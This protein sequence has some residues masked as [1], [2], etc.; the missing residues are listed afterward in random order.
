MSVYI[1]PSAEVSA[2]AHVGEGS[3]VWHQAQVCAGAQIGKN[4]IIG[5]G[6]YIDAGVKIGDNVKIQNYVSVYHGVTVED[7]V[8]IGPYVC[9]TN[10]LFPRAVNPDDSIKADDDWVLVETRICRGASLGAN[11][12]IL[13]GVIIGEWSLVGAGSVVTCSIPAHGLAWGNP[14]RLRGFVCVC[15]QRYPVTGYTADPASAGNILIH[16]TACG[17]TGSIPRTDWERIN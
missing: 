1:H 13:C 15:G 7:G 8:F 9:F 14:A 3:R 16:C 11:S 17:R 10:D 2:Q 4:C 12:T 5:K 6:V